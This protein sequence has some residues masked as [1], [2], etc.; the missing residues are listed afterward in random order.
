VV[1]KVV[2]SSP[3][4]HPKKSQVAYRK[5]LGILYICAAPKFAPLCAKFEL[6]NL[7]SMEN[8][9]P[10]KIAKL[11][12][13]EGDLSG[14]WYI[15][16]YVWD[17]QKNRLVRKR[18]YDVNNY[19]TSEERKSYAN[20]KILE[21][22]ELLK[23]G[24]HIDINKIYETESE[25][26]KSY[27]V[28]EAIEYALKIKKSS[29]RTTSYPSYK[30]TV[31]ILLKWLNNN[32]ISV[33]DIA[34]FDKLK[35]LHFDDY[36]MVDC[37]YASKT[38]NGHISY[39]KS[40]FQIL[41]DREVILNNPFKNLNKH[42]EAESRK[43]IAYNKTQIAKIKKIILENDQQLWLFIQFIYYCYLRPNEVRQLKYN[44]LK[45]DEKKIFIPKHISKNGKDGF[46]TIPETFYNELKNVRFFN[47]KSE[48]VFQSQNET[49]PISKNMM[50]ERYRKL[51]KPLNL[52]KDYTLYSWKHSGVVAAYK[53]GIDIKTIQSQCRHHSLEQTDIYLKSLGLNLNLAI[54]KIP[55]L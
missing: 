29:I 17:I 33:L 38:V 39:L 22:N 47:V 37:H 42:K 24:Y 49:L 55:E 14:R 27:T 30:S 16:F 31:K 45:L 12:D 48:F 51:I 35:A 5:E 8:I 41:V 54:N 15:E 50:G 18:F 25:E 7:N 2:G 43:N 23:E 46:V 13:C 21:I 20:R 28:A 1:P 4:F 11:N 6:K 26:I 9:Y 40:L 52:G 36:L 34:Y 53:A 44:Y 10:F 19:V 3:I 32:R